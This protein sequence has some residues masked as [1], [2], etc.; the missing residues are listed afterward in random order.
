MY[1]G[2]CRGCL[3]V[4][5]MTFSFEENSPATVFQNAWK[6]SVDSM[7]FP[8]LPFVSMQQ[9]VPNSMIEGYLTIVHS[10]EDQEPHRLRCP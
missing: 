2:R 3:L 5:K 6:L 1:K 4:S 9:E 7:I 8:E 10:Y